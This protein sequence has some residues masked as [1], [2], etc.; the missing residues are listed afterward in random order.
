VT[1]S[2]APKIK[3]ITLT[4]VQWDTVRCALLCHAV[5]SRQGWKV[6]QDSDWADDVMVAF[7]L[8]KNQLE[9]V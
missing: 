7:Q 6:R 5:D 3:T 9:A 8:V 2:T 1:A 4:D